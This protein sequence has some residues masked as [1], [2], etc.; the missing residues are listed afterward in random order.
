MLALGT[1]VC[2]CLDIGANLVCADN[3]GAKRIQILSV[4]H[5]KGK[6]R[7]RG[8]AGIADWVTVTVKAGN[9]K[10][11]KKVV[12]A[13]VIR[14]SK[15]FRRPDGRR[16]KFADNAAVIVKED[17]SPQGT[18]IKGPMAREVAERYPK[19]APLAKIVV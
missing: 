13:V 16:V 7:T 1:K 8:R 11:K 14:Q 12:E 15:E 18:E 4:K 10:M 2:K 6:R 5:Y 17:G 3:T 19:I 9:E